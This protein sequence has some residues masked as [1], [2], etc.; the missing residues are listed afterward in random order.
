MASHRCTRACGLV[1]PNGSTPLNHGLARPSQNW[2][3]LN[4][5]LMTVGGL[6]PVTWRTLR[7]PSLKTGSATSA[8]RSWPVS[9]LS[10]RKARRS[11]PWLPT[12]SSTLRSR[13]LNRESGSANSVAGKNASGFSPPGPTP[14]SN[15]PLNPG[16]TVLSVRGSTPAWPWHVAHAVCMSLPTAMSQKSA[17]PSAMAASR[18]ATNSVSRVGWGTQTVPSAGGGVGAGS[19]FWARVDAA[20]AAAAA[21]ATRRTTCGATGSLGQAGDVHRAPTMRA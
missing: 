12:T 19:A 5:A 8:Q 7:T 18:S 17:L 10:S 11:T 2:R 1:G 20:T 13:V 14:A 3:T 15:V 6:R 21:A 4:A 9:A 16:C